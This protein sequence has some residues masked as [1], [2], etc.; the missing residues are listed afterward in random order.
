M[1]KRGI[2]QF[3]AADRVRDPVVVNRL[4]EGGLVDV[5]DVFSD[6]N[7]LA[8]RDLVY[9]G[10]VAVFVEQFDAAGFTGRFFRWIF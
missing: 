10:R 7:N 5:D 1:M 3:K 6:G 8:A 4:P 2:Y 9:F